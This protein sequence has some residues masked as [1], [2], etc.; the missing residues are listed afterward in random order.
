[1]P[2]PSRSALRDLARR[3]LGRLRVLA[4][5]LAVLGVD[6][7]LEIDRAE[8]RAHVVVGQPARRDRALLVLD[9]VVGGRAGVGRG[10][11]R[12]E[13]R[14][15]GGDAGDR[16]VDLGLGQLGRGQL[17]QRR[18]LAQRVERVGHRRLLDR[19]HARLDGG[20]GVER[21]LHRRGR[22]AAAVGL[23]DAD[24]GRD[25]RGQDLGRRQR[26][27]HRL[28]G[29]HRRHAGVADGALQGQD[30]RRGRGR[31]SGGRAL[32][33]PPRPAIVRPHSK[34]PGSSSIG[35]PCGVRSAACSHAWR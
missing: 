1:M 10:L 15:D 31:R 17:A 6:R 3:G 27:R 26:R 33:G 20:D 21:G 13:Q 22:V 9:E 7:L 12:V 32:L 34:S 30:R 14:L 18:V 23:P 8:H 11:D 35:T 29:Q 24:A 16:V 4:A 5:Q 2:R 28:A 19:R 25:P